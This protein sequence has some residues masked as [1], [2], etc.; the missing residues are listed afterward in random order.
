MPIFPE[1]RPYIE[2]A[3]DEA[4]N[5]LAE[6]A[7]YGGTPSAEPVITRYRKKNANL[8]TQLLKII[9]RAGLKPWPKLFHNLRLSRQTELSACIPC[10]SFVSG[11]ETPG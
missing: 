10:M 2:A 7:Q 11:W 6:L 5:R 4:E 3:F 1:L 9:K 8:R